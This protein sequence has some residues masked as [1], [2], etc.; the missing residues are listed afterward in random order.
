MRTR[1]TTALAALLLAVTPAA[2]AGCTT[3]SSGTGSSS[4]SPAPLATPD[5]VTAALAG[6][7]ADLESSGVDLA[8]L[9]SL[10]VSVH[11]RT[12]I[13]RYWGSGPDE[14]RNVHGVTTS[15]LSTLT[16]IAVG[17]GRLRL[18]DRL[19]DLLPEHRDAMPYAERT[20]TLQQLL[21]MTAGFPADVDA[22]VGGRLQFLDGPD[23]TAGALDPALLSYQGFAYS[24]TGAQVL[25]A[26]LE[27]A[28]GEPLLD[29]AR[30]RLF[31]PLG[32]DL[33]A[34]RT[35]PVTG[36]QDPAYLAPGP[37][38]P[39]GP[40]GT[41]AGWALL[42]LRPRDLLALGRLHLADGVWQ[43]RRILPAGWVAA[44][45]SQHVEVPAPNAGY[46][47]LWWVER[48]GGRT[49]YAAIGTGG[50]LVEVVPSLD[51]V[52]VATA[53]T[54][55][56]DDATVLGVDPQ[57]LVDVVSGTLV[58]ALERSAATRAGVTATG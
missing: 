19:G 45:T 37:A 52:V 24:S 13:E 11:G 17:E 22:D 47:Y 57:L 40:D 43:G 49:A 26:V 31:D 41:A 54:Y 16:G 36:E 10:L 18:T 12:V 9:R 21:T 7:L 28:A 56:P 8:P 50:Q 32:I 38:W 27:R 25:A 55:D 1:R 23:W 46:G 44:A 3:G 2:V 51:L 20:T 34:A 5:Q 29:Y 30:S 15:V 6:G 53:Q 14:F 42:T 48:A 4:S 33:S 58:P 35:A 39:T